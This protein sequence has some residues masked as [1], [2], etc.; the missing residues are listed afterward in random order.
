[1]PIGNGQ[2]GAMLFGGIEKEVIQFN[3]QSLWSGY[4]NWDG[5]YETGDHGLDL[6]GISVRLLSIFQIEMKHTATS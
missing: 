4:N 5:E 2:M 6:T 1:M 3:E